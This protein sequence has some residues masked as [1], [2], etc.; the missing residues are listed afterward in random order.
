MI[1]Y[2][3]FQ[4]YRTLDDLIN[5]LMLVDK[6]SQVPGGCYHTTIRH[7]DRLHA[8]D[9]DIVECGVW[10]G[11]FCIFLSHIFPDSKIWVCDSFDGFQDP[12]KS[13]Y[14]GYTNEFFTPWNGQDWVRISLD[15]V[16]YNFECYG[17]SDSMA[18]SRIKFVKGWVK[19]S[20]PTSGIE[21]ISL[22]RIDVDAYS[23]TREVLDALYPKVVTGGMIIF[24]DTNIFQSVDAIKDYYR[25]NNIPL[26]LYHP[27]NDSLL[28]NMET[29]SPD[30]SPI[31]EN[32]QYPTGC[33]TIKQ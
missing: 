20:L 3:T 11:G 31:H 5:S 21:K 30:W 29:K 18:N 25:D 7:L 27:E 6:L 33:Y 9:G 12:G 24:D 8:L 4:E 16:K 14:A 13:K 15:K 26:K 28:L 32:Y 2:N 23:A 10:K 22:L 19:D 17:L 1:T